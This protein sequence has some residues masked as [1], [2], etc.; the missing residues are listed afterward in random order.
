MN[1]LSEIMQ[2]NVGTVLIGM[3]RCKYLDNQKGTRKIEN[4]VCNY[5]S[6]RFGVVER[7]IGS[8]HRMV[9]EGSFLWG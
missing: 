8:L 7:S 9:L 2:P 4:K 3:S 1:V 6:P 5:S